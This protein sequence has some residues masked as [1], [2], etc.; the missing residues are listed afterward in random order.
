MPSL[1]KE[2]SASAIFGVVCLFALYT[3][4]LLFAVGVL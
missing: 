1:R 3:L 2:V 4:L